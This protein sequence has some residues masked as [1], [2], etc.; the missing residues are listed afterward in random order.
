MRGG[1][2]DKRHRTMAQTSS[3]ARE[4]S[5]EEI[6]ASIRRIIEDSD[7]VRQS[8]PPKPERSHVA[9]VRGEIA[10]FR[11]DPD[12]VLKPVEP[13]KSSTA[14]EPAQEDRQARHA[15]DAMQALAARI[16]LRGALDPEGRSGAAPAAERNTAHSPE[17][18]SIAAPAS[19]QPRFEADHLDQDAADEAEDDYEPILDASN[20]DRQSAAVTGEVRDAAEDDAAS[21]TPAPAY[22]PQGSAAREEA[23]R[24][25]A[26]V[27]GP[28]ISQATGRQVAAAFEDLS[29]VMRAEQR[30]SFD[31]MAEEMLRPMLQE[32]L[33]NNLP[34]L[35]ERLVREEIERVVRAGRG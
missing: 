33:D 13:V 17:G 12:P 4:P 20:D 31:E 10:E 9:P 34:G 32:W 15:E 24:P 6:L 21:E 7:V 16:G 27:A 35:V 26:A 2:K 11:R 14:S 19:A 18:E 8:V 5:M 28:I 22:A 25:A 29:A 30:R 3:A 23:A 1:E